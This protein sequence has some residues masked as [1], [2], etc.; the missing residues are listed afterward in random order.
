MGPLS[1]VSEVLREKKFSKYILPTVDW[2]K[3]NI[4]TCKK[5]VIGKSIPSTMQFVEVLI[6]KVGNIFLDDQST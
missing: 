4:I 6:L 3:L 2:N 1:I 5:Y